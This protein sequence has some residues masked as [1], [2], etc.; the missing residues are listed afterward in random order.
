MGTPAASASCTIPIPPWTTATRASRNAARASGQRSTRA[1]GGTDS[2]AA[3]SR[4]GAPRVR[5]EGIEQRPDP[6][7]RRVRRLDA[8][9]LRGRVHDVEVAEVLEHLAEQ[10]EVDA[11]LQAHLVAALEQHVDQVLAGRVGRRSGGV[12]A[13]EAGRELRDRAHAGQPEE[14]GSDARRREHAIVHDQVDALGVQP[15]DEGLD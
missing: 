6:P 8:S 15:L 12:A 9:H 5:R 4:V 14:V 2:N 13:P 11:P 1:F 3:G 10:A 7:P